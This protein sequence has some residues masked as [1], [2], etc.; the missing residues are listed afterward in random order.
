MTG[1]E[2]RGVLSAVEVAELSFREA[3]AAGEWRA[4]AALVRA[5]RE[6]PRQRR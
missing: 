3:M 5:M 2:S 6:R 1:P 4:V